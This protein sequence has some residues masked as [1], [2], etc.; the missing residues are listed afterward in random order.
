MPTSRCTE[1]ANG[2][3]EDQ[4]EE[5]NEQGE[6]EDEDEDDDKDKEKH[7]DGTGKKMKMTMR[8]RMRMRIKIQQ[9]DHGVYGGPGGVLEQASSTALSRM[10]PLPESWVRTPLTAVIFRPNGATRAAEPDVLPYLTK[11]Y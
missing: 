4:N 1:A 10:H 6:D 7:S 11:Q 9:D 8:M 3:D 2:E 5:E